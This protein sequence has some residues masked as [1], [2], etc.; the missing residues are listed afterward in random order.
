MTKPFPSQFLKQ[1]FSHT[2]VGLMKT[3]NQT[4]AASPV[5]QATM[6]SLRGG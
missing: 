2:K 3:Q 1:G 5:P 4:E 6:S